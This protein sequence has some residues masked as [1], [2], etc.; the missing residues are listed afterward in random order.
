M[1]GI[2]QRLLMIY[3][4]IL[5]VFLMG[6]LVFIIVQNYGQYKKD[7][8]QN[9][10]YTAGSVIMQ[11]D[12]YVDHMNYILVDTI[13]NQKFIAVMREIR[14]EGISDQMKTYN[15]WSEVRNCIITQSSTRMLYRLSVFTENGFFAS[16]KVDTMGIFSTEPGRMEWLDEARAKKGGMFFLGPHKDPWGTEAREV[17]SVIRQIRNPVVE[18]GFLEAQLEYD[19]IEEICQLAKQYGLTIIDGDGKIFYTNQNTE[20]LRQADAE[21]L[22]LQNPPASRRNPVTGKTELVCMKES[23]QTGFRCVVSEEIS[24]LD[25]GGRLAWSL[26]IIIILLAALLSF[27]VIDLFI[28]KIMRP[29]LELKSVLENTGLETLEVSG[30]TEI[31]HSDI[32]EIN[33]LITSFRRMNQR[34]SEALIRERNAYQMQMDARFDALQAQM[35]PHFMHNMLNVIVNMA[36]EGNVREIPLVCNRLSENLRYSTSTREQVTTLQDEL[37][38]IENYLLLM[39]G[40]FEH[41]L[42]YSF[43]LANDCAGQIRLPKLTLIPFVENAVCHPYFESGKA[44]I[45]LRIETGGDEHRWYFKVQDNGNGFGE[46][47]VEELYGKIRE[48]LDHIR[49]TDMAGLEIGGLGIINTC[50]RL[51]LFS[52]GAIE[53]HMDNAETKGAVVMITGRDADV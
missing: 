11:L 7:E 26:G 52:G 27:M 20:E 6:M 37:R 33:S 25:S 30:K 21:F 10:E 19:K 35:N 29:L 22:Q 13:S 12:N 44:V 5:S 50:V 48:S 43:E 8:R 17:I 9:I 4:S 3:T 15:R 47:K 2:R 24:I 45:K 18:L 14:K 36:Y 49:K 34:L 42:E 28:R 46:G 23:G 40:R 39:K 31:S 1:K 53:V 16:S 51:N 41:K 32:D 38:F